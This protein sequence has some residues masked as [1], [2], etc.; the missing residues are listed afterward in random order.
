M[1]A[2]CYRE[3]RDEQY[4]MGSRNLK[5]FIL[6]LGRGSGGEGRGGEVCYIGWAALS[7]MK[8]NDRFSL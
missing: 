4:A 7:D 1:S 6:L 2:P 5:L 8:A 3:S